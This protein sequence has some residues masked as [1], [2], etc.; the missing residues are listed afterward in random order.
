MANKK[1]QVV[2]IGGG[3][4]TM[5]GASQ[6]LRYNKG[7]KLD[8]AIIE[9][10]ETH[11][12]QP[13][14]T[15]VGGGIKS[16]SSTAKP[17]KEVL[18]KAATWIKDYVEDIDPDNNK[19]ILRSGDEIEYEYLVVAP[20]VEYR[21]D[22]IEGL[23]DAMGKNGVCSNYMDPDYTWEVLQNFKGGTA[24][25]TQPT[26]QIK[27]PGAPQKIMY[28]TADH[29]RG[30]GVIKDTNMVFATPGS[31]VFG[32]EPFKSEL[33]RII[34]DKYDIA[35]R[36]GYKLVKVDGVNKIATYE[37][38]DLP[39]GSNHVVNDPNNK[40]NET[41]NGDRYEIKYDMM[42][43][44]PPQSA[45]RWFM[46]TKLA[47]QDGPNKGWMAVDKYSLQSTKYSNVFG[48]GD[49]TDLPT[50]KTGAGIRKQAP[51]VTESILNLIDGKEISDK[52]YS[53]YASCPLLTSKHTMLLAEFGYDGVRMTDPMLPNWLTAK[54]RWLMWIMKRYILGNLYWMLMRRGIR[55]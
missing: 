42:H 4:G 44:A 35:Q 7:G 48:L 34:N 9:P 43:L 25:F 15:L 38:A 40:I 36:Y 47:N 3:S 52:K 32:V 54:E 55:F 23:S 13:E 37:R 1:H 41:Q 10:S 30:N 24:L 45:P 28:I 21:L 26:T 2:F 39:E 53:G 12:Y 18:P 49:V 29:I 5:M 6:L 8:V 19:V 51:V 20:G 27:C 46:K 50:A 17:M 33:V 16:K 22:L 11:Y 31:V 14:W